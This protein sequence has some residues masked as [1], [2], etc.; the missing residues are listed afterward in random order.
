[1]LSIF[2]PQTNTIFYNT[3]FY[4]TIFYPQTN[5]IFYN[6]IFYNTIF[7]AQTNTIF[8]NTIFYPQTNTERLVMPNAPITYQILYVKEAGAGCGQVLG[9][10][11][12]QASKSGR[13]LYFTFKAC[14]VP[15]ASH[16]GRPFSVPVIALMIQVIKKKKKGGL[17]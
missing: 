16:T 1:M 8:Y 9:E 5:T 2:C 4:N 13:C 15:T 17:C 6:T 11:Q 10:G 3:I 7:Y 14:H 12:Q